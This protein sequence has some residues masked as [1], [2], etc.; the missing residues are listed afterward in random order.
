MMPAVMPK[1]FKNYPESIQKYIPKLYKGWETQAWILFALNNLE[2]GKG[3]KTRALGFRQFSPG[4]QKTQKRKL[5]VVMG[6]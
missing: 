1:L 2:K 6:P 3:L 5:M 4:G